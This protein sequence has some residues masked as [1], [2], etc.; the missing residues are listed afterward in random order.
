MSTATFTPKQLADLAAG[1]I[2]RT[3]APDLIEVT[4]GNLWLYE[5]KLVRKYDNEATTAT[6][7]DAKAGWDD[8]RRAAQRMR[9]DFLDIFNA[10]KAEGYAAMMAMVEDKTE[11]RH[12]RVKHLQ[13]NRSAREEI[14]VAQA[15]AAYFADLA[16]DLI[17]A[18]RITRKESARAEAKQYVES[19]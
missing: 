5:E 4:L 1:K 12:R 6:T 17:N 3:E 19:L 13:G 10:Y 9:D 2:A 18:G 16:D 8:A 15:E 14:A 7:L 11:A